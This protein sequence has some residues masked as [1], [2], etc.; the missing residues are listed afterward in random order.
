MTKKNLTPTTAPVYTLFGK[1]VKE[2]T[3]LHTLCEKYYGDFRKF[4]EDLKI[5]ERG[6]ERSCLM[7]D[8]RE[9]FWCN[10]FRTENVEL[11]RKVL[12]DCY[13]CTENE[14]LPI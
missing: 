13:Y 3:L 7:Q 12:Y 1:E 2:G 9:A 5:V 4:E 14:A 6:T 11:R 8:I 10:E